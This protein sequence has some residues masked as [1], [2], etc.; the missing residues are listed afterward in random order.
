MGL[1]GS[2]VYKAFIDSGFKMDPKLKQEAI[3]QIMR[4]HGVDEQT[5]RSAL[6]DLVIPKAKNI[7]ASIYHQF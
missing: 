3:E 6:N 1:Y 5:A 7:N 4:T 2:R